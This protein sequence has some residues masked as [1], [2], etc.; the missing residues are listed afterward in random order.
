MTIAPIEASA[1]RRAR[2]IKRPADTFFQSALDALSAHVAVLDSRGTIVAVNQAWRRFGRANGFRLPRFGIG[3]NYLACCSGADAPTSKLVRQL[4]NVLCGRSVGFSHQ[5][6]CAG[7]T[8]VRWFDMRVRSFGKFAWRRICV[9]H[10]DITELKN[11]ETT[12]RDLARRLVR[13]REAERHQLARALHDSTCQ[14]LL[15]VSLTLASLDAHFGH[16]DRRSKQLVAE[17]NEA[18]ERAQSQLRTMAYLLRPPALGDDGL[19]AALGAFVKGFSRRTGIRVQFTTDYQSRSNARVER[20]ILCVAQQA[21][22]N[23]YHHSGS[24]SARVNLK[25]LD[26]KLELHIADKGSSEPSENMEEGVGIWSMRERLMEIGGVL[27][28][29]KTA[30]GTRVRA[31]APLT[32]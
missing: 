28:I 1:A 14:E 4:R 32:S 3:T 26:D 17:M 29:D 15:V 18:I 6:A 8:G 16:H 2:E 5:Y 13:S 12:I 21:L 9:A 19:P 20:A 30:R 11:A 24:K 10:E 31:V 27:E 25:A 23:V 22:I 7:P